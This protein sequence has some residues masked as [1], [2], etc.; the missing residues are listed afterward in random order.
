MD[1]MTTYISLYNGIEISA[2]IKKS[3]ISLG[4]KPNVI[5]LD[6][7]FDGQCIELSNELKKMGYNTK[8]Y[9]VRNQELNDISLRISTVHKE[10]ILEKIK[11]NENENEEFY[12]EVGGLNHIMSG[13]AYS[14]AFRNGA[15]AIYVDENDRLQKMKFIQAPDVNN[16]RYLP[17]LALDKLHEHGPLTMKELKKY[18]Y[19]DKIANMDEEEQTEFFKK[20][21]NVYKIINK[22]TK[23]KWISYIKDTKKYEITELGE[24]ARVMINLRNEA[25][26][27]NQKD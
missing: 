20:Y 11:R 21:L 10:I 14:A 8:I 26:I 15:T 5:L 1:K 12:Y 13:A 25:K 4:N 6:L 3:L 9:E 23:K 2:T 27:N 16:V 19:A 18:L 24:M 17:E 7:L 22:L